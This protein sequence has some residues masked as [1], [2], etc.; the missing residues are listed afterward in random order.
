VGAQRFR[1]TVDQHGKTATFFSVPP[2][3]VEALGPKRRVPVRVTVKGHT[4]RSTIAPMGGEFLL[5]LNRHNR[6]AAG[7]AAGQTVTVELERDDEPRMVEVPAELAEALA[8]DADAQSGFEQLSYS[9]QREYTE[10]VAE[11][12]REETRQRRAA[13]AI[14]MLREGRA[15]R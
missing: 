13:K 9:H 10:W 4:Y 11:A 6:S 5:P 2:R 1:A 7:V 3:V 8:G 12:K 15:L 14:E